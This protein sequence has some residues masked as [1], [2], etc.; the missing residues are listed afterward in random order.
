[1]AFAPKVRLAPPKVAKGGDG[2]ESIPENARYE[3]SA[4]F[5]YLFVIGSGAA[6]GADREIIEFRPRNTEERRLALRALDRDRLVHGC[7][8]PS[9]ELAL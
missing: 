4:I 8:Y 2:C 3:T 9:I 7:D 5:G 6:I 1:M